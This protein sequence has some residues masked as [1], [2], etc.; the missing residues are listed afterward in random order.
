MFNRLFPCLPRKGLYPVALFYI[1][2]QYK[3]MIPKTVTKTNIHR[4]RG[5]GTYGKDRERIEK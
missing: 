2:I 3:R 4:I 5:N 1:I